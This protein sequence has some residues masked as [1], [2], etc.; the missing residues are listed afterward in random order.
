M[1]VGANEIT[2]GDLDFNGSSRGQVSDFITFLT[3]DMIKVHAHRWELSTTILTGLI[4]DL[5]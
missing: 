1:A 4:F 5:I 2:L 3:T